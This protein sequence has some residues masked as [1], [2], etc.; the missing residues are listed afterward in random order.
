MDDS[1]DTD[2]IGVDGIDQPPA[3]HEDLSHILVTI[4]FRNTSPL[5][6]LINQ[7]ISPCEHL[8]GNIAG[9]K[10]GV[11]LDVTDDFFQIVQRPV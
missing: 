9:V 6:G 8:A 5:S 3:M 1:S 10:R 2:V 4:I 7:G 11:F